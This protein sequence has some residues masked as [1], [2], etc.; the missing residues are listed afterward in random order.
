MRKLKD[1]SGNIKPGIRLEDFT[2]ETLARMVKLYSKLYQAMDGFWYLTI[3]DK[4]NNETAFNM[5]VDTWRKVCPYE[6]K[7]I[8]E[9]LNISG[10]N[11]AALMK[12]IQFTPWFMSSEYIVEMINENHAILTVTKCTTLT[13]LEK[14]GQGREIEIC[15]VFEPMVFQLYANYFNP[16]ITVQ[17]LVAPPRASSSGICCQWE[18]MHKTGA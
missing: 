14:E 8:T 4:I 10:N 3:M 15:T 16:D 2:P 17:Y 13:A 18:F 1:Y 11:V 12:A 6:M 9:T 7:R 5:D